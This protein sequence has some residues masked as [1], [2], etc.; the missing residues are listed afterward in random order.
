VVWRWESDAF[1]TAIPMQDPD[2][3][4]QATLINLRFP[5]QYYDAESKLHYNWNRYYDPVLGRYI[6]SDPIG[7][8]GGLNTFGYVDQ[9]PINFID[10]YSLNPL[11]AGEIG[12]RVGLGISAGIEFAFNGVGLGILIYE[13]SNQNESSK[14][15]DRQ[16]EYDVAKKF[17]DTPPESSGNDCADLS[18]KI[19]HAKQCIK[20]YEGWDAKWLPGRH[21]E[22]IQ[23]WRNRLENLIKEHQKNFTNKWCN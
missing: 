2:G 20:L 19:N 5:G 12:Y 6:S 7:L 9:N 22:K 21:S 16:K 23:I 1:G 14:E 17:C 8:G 3:D 15:E 11:V 10:R 18:N 13:M 4:G